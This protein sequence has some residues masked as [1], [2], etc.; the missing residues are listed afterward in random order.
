MKR[1]LQLRRLATHSKPRPGSRTPVTLKEGAPAD[2]EPLQ[3]AAHEIWTRKQTGAAYKPA[4]PDPSDVYRDPMYTPPARPLTGIGPIIA[5][6]KWP[7]YD[8]RAGTAHLRPPQFDDPAT[9]PIGD[10]P[11]D[12]PFQWTQLKDPFKYWDQQG[13]RNYGEILHDHDQFTDWLS[14]GPVPDWKKP[15]TGLLGVFG[16]FALMGLSVAYWDPESRRY[17]TPR[18]FPYDGLRVELGGDPNDKT[19]AW[20]SAHHEARK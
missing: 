2:P 4:G 5:P 18:E 10:Y 16:V 8:Q 20:M 3:E 11:R 14:H 19:D 13:R 17:W 7:E 6:L 12:I 15:F 1:L 9:A